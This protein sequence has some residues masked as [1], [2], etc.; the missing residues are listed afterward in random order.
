MSIIQR[1]VNIHWP[2]GYDPD[3]ADLFA[4]NTVVIDDPSGALGEGVTFDWAPP[5]D[6]SPRPIPAICTAVTNCGTPASV[7]V[8]K[9]TAH[10]CLRGQRNITDVW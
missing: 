5:R 2:D 1:S 9:L 7:R 8:R 3:H 6:T 10:P 4:H